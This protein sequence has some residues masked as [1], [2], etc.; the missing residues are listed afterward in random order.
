MQEG[1]IIEEG[2]VYNIF[3]NPQHRISQRV[4]Q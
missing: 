4:Y 2:S 1:K 3:A